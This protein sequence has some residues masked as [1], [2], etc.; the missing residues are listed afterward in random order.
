MLRTA[1][2]LSTGLVT[3]AAAGCHVRPDRGPPGTIYEQ[4]NRAVIHDPFPSRFIGPEIEARV[5]W[6]TRGRL[7]KRRSTRPIPTRVAAFPVSS[8]AA[9]GPFQEPSAADSVATLLAS[10]VLAMRFRIST[11]CCSLSSLTA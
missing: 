9:H 8:A 2:I 4:R 10:R 3:L 1:L 6:I 7:T 11:P 5:R